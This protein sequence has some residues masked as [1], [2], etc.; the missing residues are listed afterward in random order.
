M[1]NTMAASAAA[2][3]EGG[4]GRADDDEEG[5]DDDRRGESDGIGDNGG[6]AALVAPED[7]LVTAV[8]QVTM[9]RVGGALSG[10]E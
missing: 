7:A 2:S 9:R 10:N 1:S 5:R 6:S 3:S 4:G 8:E